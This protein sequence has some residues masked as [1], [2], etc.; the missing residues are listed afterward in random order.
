MTPGPCFGCCIITQV[1]TQCMQ[2]SFPHS[3]TGSIADWNNRST[4]HQGISC[5][6]EGKANGLVLRIRHIGSEDSSRLSM[7]TAAA[8]IDLGATVTEA[9]WTTTSRTLAGGRRQR[10]YYIDHL[11]RRQE[12]L[13]QAVDGNGSI[14]STTFEFSICEEPGMV[15]ELSI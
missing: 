3:L 13:W 15:I 14:T 11:G 2:I 4:H 8:A 12:E 9:E 7:A 5:R 1:G 10:L 6:A